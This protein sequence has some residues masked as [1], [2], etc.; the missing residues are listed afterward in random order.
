MDTEGSADEQ[1]YWSVLFRQITNQYVAHTR[2]F[3]SEYG[4]EDSHGEWI[5]PNDNVLKFLRSPVKFSEIEK[6]ESDEIGTFIRHGWKIDWTIND[7]QKRFVEFGGVMN[8]DEN[9]IEAIP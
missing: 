9:S 4:Y 1:V 6:L 5:E 3:P 2:V 8:D 7:L